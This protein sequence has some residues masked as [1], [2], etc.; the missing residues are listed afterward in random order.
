MGTGKGAGG[1][2]AW[3]AG[4]RGWR[5]HGDEGKLRQALINLLGN[6]VKFTERGGVTLRVTWLEASSQGPIPNRQWLMANGQGLM[7]NGQGP[8]PNGQWLMANGQ[9]LMTRGDLRCL[10]EVLDTGPGIAPELLGKLFQPFQQG[11]ANAHKGGTGLGLAITRRLA[12]AMGGRIGVESA[13][14]AVF[15]NGRGG[16]VDRRGAIQSSQALTIAA[17]RP[18]A[19]GPRTGTQA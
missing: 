17:S 19:T 8:I 5:A 14:G 7:A 18:P 16:G 4:Q 9:G 6:A 12:E 15:A 2:Q 3:V 11:D 10:F 1:W 13:A